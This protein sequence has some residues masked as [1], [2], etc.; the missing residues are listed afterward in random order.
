MTDDGTTRTVADERSR[1]D[2]VRRT[3]LATVD[4]VA[5]QLVAVRLNDGPRRRVLAD[6]L[7]KV[8]S[9]LEVDHDGS[10]GRSVAVLRA[11]R[12]YLLAGDHEAALLALEDVRGVY[13]PGMI[14]SPPELGAGT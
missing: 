12:A 10:A 14:S 11:A 4:A 6:T 9:A 7:G 13:P 5:E 2:S 3:V 1:I 8:A